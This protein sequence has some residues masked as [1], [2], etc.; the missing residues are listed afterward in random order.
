MRKLLAADRQIRH[1]KDELVKANLRLVVGIA[2]KHINAQKG[3]YL[4]DL[5]QEGHLGLLRA[6]EKF[7]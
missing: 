2:K 7:P 6:I 1:L 4:A 3:A 5:I